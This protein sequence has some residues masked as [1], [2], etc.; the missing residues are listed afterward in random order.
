MD[1]CG[2][3]ACVYRGRDSQHREIVGANATFSASR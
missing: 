2:I 3:Q 1:R